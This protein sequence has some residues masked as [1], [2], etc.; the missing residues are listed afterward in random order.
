MIGLL[1]MHKKGGAVELRLF[2]E[3]DKGH[4]DLFAEA[5][6]GDGLVRLTDE[7]AQDYTGDKAISA[8][9]AGDVIWI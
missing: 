3:S 5:K 2:P 7:A 4:A 9:L 6:S 8:A 1:R